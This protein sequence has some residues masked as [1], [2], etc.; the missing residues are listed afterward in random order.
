MCFIERILLLN[1]SKF[2]EVNG[3]YRQ[4]KTLS[5]I[6]KNIIL[7]PEVPFNFLAL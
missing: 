2:R 1:D 5:L 7:P 6:Y 4:R 3:K